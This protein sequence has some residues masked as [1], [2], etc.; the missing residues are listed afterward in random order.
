MKKIL[1]IILILIGINKDTLKVI[2]DNSTFE[3]EYFEI[4][5]KNMFDKSGLYYVLIYLDTCVSCRNSKL[6]LKE[7]YLINNVV[8]YYC[9]YI[10]GDFGQ[11]YK[12]QNNLGLNKIEE[13]KI[14]YV[15]TLFQ[16]D[17]KSI[18]KEIIGYQ[19]IVDFFGLIIYPNY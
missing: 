18:K 17:S 19:N 5:K 8:T 4:D 14:K 9:S 15:P 13:I 7:Q 2:K 10:N 6:F 3:Y 1:L 12:G 16:I 11:D